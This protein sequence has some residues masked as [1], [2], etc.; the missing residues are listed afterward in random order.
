[1]CD[2]SGRPV[3]SPAHSRITGSSGQV[4]ERRHASAPSWRPKAP[5]QYEYS[6]L[7]SRTAV[8]RSSRA[9][10]T[11]ASGPDTCRRCTGARRILLTAGCA[12]E[13]Q[14]AGTAHL[15]C[16][17]SLYTARAILPASSLR[18]SRVS[19]G[20]QVGGSTMLP[21]AAAASRGPPHR[22]VMLRFFVCVGLPNCNMRLAS[23][24]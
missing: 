12:H 21:R 15:G 22:R 16:S 24:F 6:R 14:A 9:C 23:L 3:P 10:R 5:A 2:A 19:N 7:S 20:C 1:M 17:S 4:S 11:R 8:G 18:S 13:C